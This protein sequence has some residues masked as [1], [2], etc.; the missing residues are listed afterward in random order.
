M[1]IPAKISSRFAAGVVGAVANSA[2]LWLLGAAGVPDMLGVSMAPDFSFGWLYPRL[3][4]GGLWGMLFLLPFSKTIGVGT[5]LGLAPAAAAM[6][7][8]LPQAG[9]GYL[10]L[11]LGTLAPLFVLFYNLL[12]GLTT[13]AWLKAGRA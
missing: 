13:A 2:A 7:Y 9:K 6:L 1:N 4:W 8:F 3:V 5:L 10:G 11:E 12:W